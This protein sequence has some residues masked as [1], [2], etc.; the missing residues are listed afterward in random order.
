MTRS[1]RWVSAVAFAALGLLVGA[2]ALRSQQQ[3]E[4][5]ATVNG[6][7]IER[8]RVIADLEQRHGYA[9]V[10]TEIL[11]EL[12]LEAA[13]QA[14]LTPTPGEL[15]AE[16][17]MFVGVHFAYRDDR[18]QRWLRDFGRDEETL[19]REIRVQV[20]QRKLRSRGIALDEA[21]LRR[22][23]EENKSLYQRPETV[24]FRRIIVPWT[25]PPHLEEGPVVS[26]E[27]QAAAEKVLARL[28][29]GEKFEDVAA[30]VSEDPD[31]ARTGGQVGPVPVERLQQVAAPIEEALRHLEP[32]Q[33]APQPVF[34]ASRFLVI[35]L[36]DRQPP[37]S[38]KFED[39][40]QR[41]EADY[42]ALKLPPQEQF[43]ADLLAKAD[44]KIH[45]P[46]YQHVPLVPR[47]SGPAG[48][49]LP[50]WLRDTP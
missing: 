28:R 35:Q 47:W 5:I 33:Y 46:R 24:L 34:Y 49:A 45:D 42:L 15:A 18:Y 43:L 8:A 27:N 38:G 22:Y 11:S 25:G 36:L 6:R 26:P 19:R 7:P 14:G 2:S 37:T 4:V 3:P 31:L 50:G 44:I 16:Y 41:V 10:G 21:T 48:L 17:D 20:A 39:H 32:G 9:F 1:G 40:R 13:D 12:I 30:Q 29:A 23:F